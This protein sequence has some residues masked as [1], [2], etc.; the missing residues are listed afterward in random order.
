M[1][2]K[3]IL[4]FRTPR[5]EAVCALLF[6]LAQ[7]YSGV[8]VEVVALPRDV[9]A[10]TAAGVRPRWVAARDNQWQVVRELRARRYDMVWVPAE[11]DAPFALSL[12]PALIRTGKKRVFDGEGTESQLTVRVLA[13]RVLRSLQQESGRML[14]FALMPLVVVYLVIYTV[15]VHLRRYGRPFRARR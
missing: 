7:E 13:T 6:R 5:P 2:V 10:Y 4:V 14:A 9:E 11:D 15:G 8:T 3:N 12:L 1:A